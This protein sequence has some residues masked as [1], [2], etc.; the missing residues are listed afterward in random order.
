[1]YVSFSPIILNNIFNLLCIIK[2]YVF[3]NKKKLTNWISF[4][5]MFN[6]SEISAA[7]ITATDY[8]GQ[9]VVKMIY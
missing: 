8:N 2:A 6:T 5:F 4:C 9:M 7:I 1:M 3:E